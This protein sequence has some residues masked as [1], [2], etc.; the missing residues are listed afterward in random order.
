MRVKHKIQQKR[1]KAF[2]IIDP[3]L[4]RVD[5]ISSEVDPG[6]FY[7]HALAIDWLK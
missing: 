2:L 1:V 6:D 4:G 7:V 3:L 5:E